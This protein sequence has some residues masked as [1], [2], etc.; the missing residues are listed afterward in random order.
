[1]TVS[2]V[3][4]AA[5]PSGWARAR[6]GRMP[7]AW[8][9]PVLAALLV[10]L[11]VVAAGRGA[12][13][14]SAS[15]VLAILLHKAGLA[16]GGFEPQQMGVLWTIRLPRVMLGVAVGALLGMAG[17]TLQGLFRNPLADPGLI[18][19]SSGAALA[20]ALAIVF[21]NL[22]WPALAQAM[23]LALLPVAAFAGGVLTTLLV[24]RIGRTSLGVSVAA[25]LLAGIAMNAIAMALIGLASY[26]A[27]DE[28]L[29]NL[30]FWNLGS[31]APATW[32]IVG[33]VSLVGAVALAGMWRLRLG[34]NAMALGEAEARH[35]GVA[36]ESLKALAVVFSA[37]AVGMA[38][39][40]CGII[41]FLGLVAPHC[42]RLMAGPDARVV[43][44]GAAL[45][46]AALTVAADLVARLI[47]APAELPIGVL[48]ALIGAPFFLFLLLR[49]K[50]RM[51][52]G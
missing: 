1:M 26:M 49:A 37:L 21:G 50:G 29:R 18:G 41:G 47:I 42:I 40:F 35:L 12:Y 20:V 28:Q 5:P 44:P 2:R 31:L 15:N 52:E 43:L 34:L 6:A 36:V 8:L 7:A 17:A 32:P 39:A 48:T 23:G 11:V 27:T 46:G 13:P 51:F 22:W 3:E 33:V 25:M 19:V 4:T 14:I 9:F 16:Q 10:A 24:Y 30:T 45:L 38:V